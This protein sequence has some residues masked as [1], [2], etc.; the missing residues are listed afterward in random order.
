[1]QKAYPQS[2]KLLAYIQGRLSASEMAEI[3]QMVADD[4]GLAAEIEEIRLFAKAQG[5]DGINKL[6]EQQK[7]IQS[8]IPSQSKFRP[9]PLFWGSVAA[10]ILALMAIGLW[11]FFSEQNRAPDPAQLLAWHELPAQR[12]EE[13]AR[14]QQ[15][16]ANGLEGNYNQV[17]ENLELWLEDYPNDTEA[18][19][20]LG[21]AL[22]MSD[23]QI[24][25]E[26]VFIAI[27]ENGALLPQTRL[28]ARWYRILYSL[29][30]GTDHEA[31]CLALNEMIPKLGTSRKK[32]AQ[33]LIKE[34]CKD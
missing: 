18:Q 27:E 12:G 30:N 8:A 28:D 22:A 16:L 1:M 31:T 3:D 7:I 13:H 20:Y 14:W 2:E 17:A 5:E 34:Y 25:A 10:G 33:L 4:P 9:I 21:R 11:W 19:I 23:R 6:S 32:Q 15:I 24:E 26:K 29:L